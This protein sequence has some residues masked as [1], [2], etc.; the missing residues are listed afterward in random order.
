MSARRTERAVELMLRFADRTGLSSAREPRRYLW[1]DAFAVCTFLG[2]HRST[3]DRRFRELALRLVD[4]VHHVLGR[5]RPDDRRSG[6]ISGLSEAEGEKHPTAGGLRIGK[7]L[8]ERPPGEPLVEALEWDRDGQYFHYLTKW[9]HAL[10]QVSR[11]TG[12]ARYNTWARELARAAYDAFTYTPRG[13]A[14]RMYWK[15]SIDLTRPLVPS[16]GQ[17]DPLDGLITCIQLDSTFS[18]SPRVLS[19]VAAGFAT[20][21]DRQSF[22]TSDPLGLGGLLVDASRVHQLV[23]Q[24]ALATDDGL[25]AALL[26]AALF[27]LHAYAERPDLQAPAARRLAFRE[28]GLAIGLAA[29]EHLAKSPPPAGTPERTN[30]DRLLRYRTVRARIEELW[31]RPDSR[32]TRSWH[33]HVDINDVML[34]TALEPDGFIELREPARRAA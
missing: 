20:M 30:V 22:P 12:D 5:H 14:K 27:G 28:L 29:V 17:H 9:M 19:D 33:D 13:V 32:D 16:M 7:P 1:T 3:G 23:A 31:L 18:S 26:G 6:W 21:V 15:M 24:G 2:L 8:P 4:Q 11:A 25:L 10:D 34:A